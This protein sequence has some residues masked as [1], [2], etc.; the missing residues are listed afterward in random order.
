MIE[1]LTSSLSEQFW[2]LDN[3]VFKGSFMA[4]YQLNLLN[5]SQNIICY[6]LWLWVM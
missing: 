5:V 3:T 6:E 1:F 2:Y 4:Y